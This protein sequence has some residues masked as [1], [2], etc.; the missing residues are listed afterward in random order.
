LL[1]ALRRATPQNSAAALG[2]MASNGTD[3][4]VAPPPGIGDWHQCGVG[5]GEPIGAL[6]I[7]QDRTSAWGSWGISAELMVRVLAGLK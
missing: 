5:A 4:V 2:D 7:E 1:S 3:A 6:K